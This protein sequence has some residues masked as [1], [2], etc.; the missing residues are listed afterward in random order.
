MAAQHHKPGATTPT[1]RR[2]TVGY[3]RDWKT[4]NK[5]TSITLKGGWLNEAGFVTGQKV[6]VLTGPGQ[7]I[8][9]LAG[10]K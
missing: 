4:H 5:A 7:L 2:Y 6:E 10:E 9:R 1:T 3:I 8:I